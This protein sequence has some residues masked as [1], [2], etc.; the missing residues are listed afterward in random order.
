MVR[1]FER[2]GDVIICEN[3]DSR[4]EWDKVSKIERERERLTK[5]R[6]RLFHRLR[7]KVSFISNLKG[8]KLLLPER[9]REMGRKGDVERVKEK[10]EEKRKG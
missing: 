2:K 3:W 7:Q 4:E 1:A 5:E 6:V 9:E 10:R 8:T